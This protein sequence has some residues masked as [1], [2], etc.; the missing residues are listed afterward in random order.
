MK[1]I[2]SLVLIIM[3]SSCGFT[4]TEVVE[5]RQV[6][7]PVVTTPVTSTIYTLPIHQSTIIYYDDDPLDVTTTTIDYYQ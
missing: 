3:L 2:A 6:V 5:Y 7:T 4:N 1:W